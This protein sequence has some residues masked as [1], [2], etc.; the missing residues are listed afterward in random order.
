MAQG[1]HNEEIICRAGDKIRLLEMLYAK[2]SMPKLA[3]S[4]REAVKALIMDP[5][6]GKFHHVPGWT[7]L[8]Q[9]HGPKVRLLS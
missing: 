3:P 5:N 8:S 6:L 1:M 7:Y 2:G 9:L 4:A